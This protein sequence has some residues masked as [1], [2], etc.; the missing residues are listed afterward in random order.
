MFHELARKAHYFYY[1]KLRLATCL[2]SK[3]DKSDL[4]LLGGQSKY[5]IGAAD[6][7][8]SSGPIGVLTSH[9]SSHLL[10]EP[11]SLSPFTSSGGSK[12]DWQANWRD[13]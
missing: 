12:A 13:S 5:W 3:C 11:R 2:P 6:R 8:A 1:T 10:S 9:F 7:L 4:E